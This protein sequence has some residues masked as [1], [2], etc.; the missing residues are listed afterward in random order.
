MSDED[1]ILQ[2][3]TQARQARKQQKLTSQQQVQTAK[4]LEIAPLEASIS[5]EQPKQYD[6]QSLVPVKSKISDVKPTERSQPYMYSP[7][8]QAPV[9][10]DDLDL[11]RARELRMQRKQQRI[12]HT[13]EIVDP[14]PVQA[15]ALTTSSSKFP[16]ISK[17]KIDPMVQ[18]LIDKSN[19]AFNRLQN[20]F[21]ESFELYSQGEAEPKELKESTE[22]QMKLSSPMD[23]KKQIDAE[24]KRIEAEKIEADKIEE[25]ERIYRAQEQQAAEETKE[26]QKVLDS[27]EQQKYEKQQELEEAIQL[28]QGQ[29]QQ[30]EEDKLQKLEYNLKKLKTQLQIEEQKLQNEIQAQNEVYEKELKELKEKLAQKQ[31]M[32]QERLKKEIQEVKQKLSSPPRVSQTQVVRK[33]PPQNIVQTAAKLDLRVSQ[34][35][36]RQPAPSPKAQVAQPRQVP[37]PRQMY[38]PGYAPQQYGYGQGYPQGYGQFPGYPRYQ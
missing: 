8:A 26:T 5:R 23:F 32:D 34:S 2:Q 33:S 17:K 16:M 18:D 36:P 27:L 7:K 14:K 25:I 29:L 35:V 6:T 13:R 1:L 20:V 19:Q 12:E 28:T 15:Q 9:N 24:K 4:K 22:N 11:Q 30:F 37:S 21:E 38:G 31:Q 10:Q 3:V